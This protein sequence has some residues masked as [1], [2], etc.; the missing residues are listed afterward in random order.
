MNSGVI[1]SGIIAVALIGAA[2]YATSGGDRPA[3]APEA[4]GQAAPSVLVAAPA[5]K[6]EVVYFH[7]TQRCAA[8]IAVSQYARKTVENKFPEEYQSGRIVFMEVN[9]ELPENQ[10]LVMKYRARGSSLFV[11]AIR[12]GRDDISEDTR[13][14]RLVGSEPQFTSYF[15]DKLKGLFGE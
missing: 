2:L 3:A 12:G 15:E 11:N 13:V 9:G 7:G 6:V 8:C 14:W 5:E 10:E 4:S 1:Y